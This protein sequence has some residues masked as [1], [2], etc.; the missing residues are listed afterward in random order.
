LADGAPELLDDMEIFSPALPSYRGACACCKGTAQKHTLPDPHPGP[1]PRDPRD[2][3]DG[4]SPISIT[5]RMADGDGRS[6]FEEL[7]QGHE[8]ETPLPDPALPTVGPTAA[9]QRP[10]DCPMQQHA[11]DRATNSGRDTARAAAT[12]EPSKQS[13]VPP[14]SRPGAI[15]W[16]P[17][18]LQG[19]DPFDALQRRRVSCRCVWYPEDRGCVVV[20]SRG[21]L[22]RATASQQTPASA[23]HC[24]GTG[25]QN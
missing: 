25:D 13:H 14:G 23:G 8:P 17:R 18:G 7:P 15:A 12:G 16:P 10:G 24:C 11:G 20:P 4:A 6:V 1:I 21:S 19:G 2:K 5:P 9:L 3:P 22:S